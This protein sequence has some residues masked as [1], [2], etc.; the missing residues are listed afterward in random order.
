MFVFLFHIATAQKLV[1]YQKFNKSL[2]KKLLNYILHHAET[3]FDI[4]T[5]PFFHDL[6]HLFLQNRNI[7][8]NALKIKLYPLIVNIRAD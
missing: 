3:Y 7:P 2:Q 6:K 8:L 4:F 1:L 5:H